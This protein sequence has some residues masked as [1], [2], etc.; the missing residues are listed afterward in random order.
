MLIE[1]GNETAT[2]GKV[3][4]D[5]FVQLCVRSALIAP[6]N[7]AVAQCSCDVHYR[8]NIQHVL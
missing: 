2:A 1:R 5:L 8:E 7:G 4:G 6:I 3:R